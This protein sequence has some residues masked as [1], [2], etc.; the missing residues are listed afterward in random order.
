VALGTDSGSPGVE[1][2]AAVIEEMKLLMQAGYSLPEAIPCATV[3]GARLAG[4]EFGLI[5]SGRPATFVIVD[6]SPSTLPE[7][8]KRVRAV[9]IDGIKQVEAG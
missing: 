2:G 7:S 8:L 6:G 3:N 5:E 4:G 1:H 9:F